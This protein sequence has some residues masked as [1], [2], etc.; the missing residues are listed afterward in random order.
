MHRLIAPL[1]GDGVV[2]GHPL[3]G[4]GTAKDGDPAAAGARAAGATV[5]DAGHGV[6]PG[7]DLIAQGPVLSEVRVATAAVRRSLTRRPAGA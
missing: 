5:T 3:R 2:F 6:T 7:T 1:P 4:I